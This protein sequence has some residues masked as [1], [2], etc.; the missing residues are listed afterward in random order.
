MQFQ[1]LGS[2]QSNSGVATNFSSFVFAQSDL[3]PHRDQTPTLDT[4]ETNDCRPSEG[5][6]VGI[7]S[8]EP[9]LHDENHTAHD[10]ANASPQI[11]DNV[12]DE[13][14]N[15]D[16]DLANFGVSTHIENETDRENRD[17]GRYL[18]I[19]EGTEIGDV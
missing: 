1:T 6:S 15:L 18:A 3:L 7:T 9:V 12:D 19:L 11:R 17:T 10:I 2:R 14:E 4:L 16:N 8:L 5:Q 13:L